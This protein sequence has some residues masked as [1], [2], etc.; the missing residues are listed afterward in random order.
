M[1]AYLDLVKHILDHGEYRSDRTGTGTYSIFGYQMRVDI[2][3]GFPLLTT[4]KVLFD[5]VVAELLWFLRGDTHLSG[6]GDAKAIWE[7]WA[8]SDGHLGPI[9]GHQ[10][11]QWSS[12]GGG[13]DQFQAV[14]TEMATH[15][16]SR[17]L[18]VNAWNVGDLP[19]MALP[20]CHVLYQFYV[21]GRYLDMQLYQR[22]ADVA[23]G[24]PFNMASYALLLELVAAHHG[25][26]ARFFIHT[27][28]DAHIYTNHIEGMTT[29]LNRDP[30]PL[31]RI[32]VD[33]TNFPSLSRDD[34]QLIGYD[35]HPFIKFPVAV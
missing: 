12:D 21:S 1:Q 18:L 11:R 32:Q 23:I 19:K 24:V 25:L 9:Y 2:R 27:F 16:H 30:R 8:D 28:G 6:L 35:P 3:D 33:V 10:W 7:P 20:P 15:P 17:R 34:I 13:I 26:T 5:K 14:M 31:P 29:Q 22:S 4:K